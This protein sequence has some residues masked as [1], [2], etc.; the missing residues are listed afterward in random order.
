MNIGFTAGMELPVTA[1]VVSPIETDLP[2]RIKGKTDEILKVYKDLE[3]LMMETDRLRKT[4]GGKDTAD[5]VLKLIRAFRKQYELDRAEFEIRVMR[6]VM[7][8]QDEEEAEE[9]DE[10][11][12]RKIGFN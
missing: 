6:M 1:P 5:A 11:T 9:A 2:V 8:A 10:N 12:P 7:A 4:E 3:E